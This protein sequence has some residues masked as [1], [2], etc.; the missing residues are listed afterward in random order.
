MRAFWISR[1]GHDV[2][3]WQMI[4]INWPFPKAGA[5][6]ISDNQLAEA[7]AKDAYLR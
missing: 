3:L 2:R 1:G 6:A 5:M 7:G 4:T